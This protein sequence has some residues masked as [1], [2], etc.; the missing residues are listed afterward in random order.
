MRV[1]KSTVK[2]S[3]CKKSEDKRHFY[4]LTPSGTKVA[5]D[6]TCKCRVHIT[7]SDKAKGLT[8]Q[9]VK[10]TCIHCGYVNPRTQRNSDK[11]SAWEQN[12]GSII[13]RVE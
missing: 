3:V 11:F 6:I 10:I 9:P 1:K 13:V 7:D 8:V 2:F 4:K 12:D 5:H